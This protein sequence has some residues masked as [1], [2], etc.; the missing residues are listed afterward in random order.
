M[1]WRVIA[2][3]DWRVV[4][5]ARLPKAALVG[6]IGVVSIAAYVYPVV[7]TPPITTSRFGAFVGGWLG[8]LLAPIGV[9]FGYGAIAREHE[10][11]AL[12]LALSMPHGRSTLVLGRFVGRAGVLGAAIAVGMVIAGVL[13]VY[14]F[15]TLQPLRLLA[16]VLLCV[17]HGAIWVGI[18]VAASALVATNRRALV[19]GV[20][21][22]FVLVIVWDPV[23]AGT[24]AGLVAAG[25]TDGPIRTAVRVSAQ[26][27]PGS[28][29]ET[30]VTA[31][32]ASDRG[33][34]TWYDGPALALPVFVGWLLGPL[35]VAV[36][37]FEWR[38]LA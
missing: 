34:G 30:L 26:L 11:G 13:V 10:S 33:A 2:R 28:A 38:D 22:L 14:P 17:A 18:G 12:R 29:F 37:R 7:G 1:T 36:L 8:A 35:S 6:L 31:L 5:D 23:T 16:F 15:G 20:A 21:A 25:V 27:D 19:L 9:L 4:L 3:R 24:E 32:A